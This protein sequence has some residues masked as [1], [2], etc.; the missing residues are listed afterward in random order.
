MITCMQHRHQVIFTSHILMPWA[1]NAL[2]DIILQ[3]GSI[4]RIASLYGKHRYSNSFQTDSSGAQKNELTYM[5]TLRIG[6]F[7]KMGVK[8]ETFQHHY[9][10]RK[11]TF[12]MFYRWVFWKLYRWGN[13]TVTLLFFVFLFFVFYKNKVNWK[14]IWLPF[15]KIKI[16]YL[17]PGGLIWTSGFNDF[18]LE[19]LPVI[20][21]ISTS[22]Y[23]DS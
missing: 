9:H 10:F 17:S 1:P 23:V 21:L 16:F 11:N 19:M 6:N 8:W 5:L 13:P 7:S 20:A 12:L 4:C 14:E 18:S 15:W 22:L 3:L 2:G